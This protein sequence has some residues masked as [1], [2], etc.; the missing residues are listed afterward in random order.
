MRVVRRMVGRMVA[1]SSCTTQQQATV[2]RHGRHIM[3]VILVHSPKIHG[4]NHSTLIP[5]TEHLLVCLDNI[6]IQI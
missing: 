6:I 3:V 4:D 1:E 5:V 2:T